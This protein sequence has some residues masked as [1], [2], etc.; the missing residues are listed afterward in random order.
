M[1]SFIKYAVCRLTVLIISMHFYVLPSVHFYFNNY[2][3][4]KRM[5]FNADLTGYC[6]F[7]SRYLCLQNS[8]SA[9]SVDVIWTKSS[10]GK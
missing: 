1:V 3:S 10:A 9:K 8:D 6:A 7:D 2:C 5:F 4:N